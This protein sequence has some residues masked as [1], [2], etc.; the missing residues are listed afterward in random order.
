MEAASHRRFIAQLTLGLVLL[1]TAVV[2]FNRAVNPYRLFASDWVKTADKPETFTH[3]R[4]VKAMQVRHMKPQSIILGSSRAETGVAPAHPGWKFQPV[5]NLGLSD[6]GL[7]EMKRYFD[8]A[9]AVSEIRQALLLLD[10]TAF[11]PGGKPAPDFREQRIQKLYWEDYV[12]GLCSWDAMQGSLST[13]S[14][15]PGQKR[16]LTDGSRDPIAEDE[17]VRSKGGVRK[18]FEMVEGRFTRTAPEHMHIDEDMK[19]LFREI[20]ATARAHNVDLRLAVTPVHA[21]YLEMLDRAGSGA[22]LEEWKRVITR[23]VEEEAAGSGKPAFPLLDFSG[24][25]SFTTEA[26]PDTGLG[27]YYLEGSH[28]NK[29]LGDELLNRLFGDSAT[30]KPGEFGLPLSSAQLEAHLAAIRE[31]RD[32]YR[33]ERAAELAT[34]PALQ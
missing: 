29:K 25:N 34:L 7:Y 21:R 6:A 5:Y 24:Y 33:R 26:V 20:M 30:L 8:H 18:A 1:L 27:L 32:Q 3:L 16:Y 28:F 31:A 2:L 22:L 17:R 11:L 13:W 15:M 14:G 19:K 4:L 9:C 23:M 12:L 10:F